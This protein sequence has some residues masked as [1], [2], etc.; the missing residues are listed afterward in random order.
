MH[1][2]DQNALAL[3]TA[4]LA[5]LV[6]LELL[7]QEVHTA[8][9][10]K[11]FEGVM[12]TSTHV[13]SIILQPKQP[14]EKNVIIFRS[15]AIIDYFPSS[16][17]DKG[18]YLSEQ[19]FISMYYQNMAADALGKGNNDLAYSY[20]AR[21]MNIDS[22]NAETI[23]TLAVLYRKDGHVDQARALYEYV[24]K[25]DIESVHTL[26]NFAVLLKKVGDEETLASIGE[27][28]LK[29]QDSNPYR[30]YDIGN[31]YL[32]RRD[33]QRAQVFFNR[34]IERGP[35]LSEGYFGL[36]KVHYLEGDLDRAEKMMV[37]ALSL[38][39]PSDDQRL[40]TAKLEALQ[41]APGH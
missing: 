8:P 29:A 9:I 6:N 10:Y 37:K 25:N 24:I 32:S 7:Y 19:A 2:K 5:K 33:F 31:E 26:S 3:L 40:Y 39:Y 21:A 14:Q 20:L 22:A 27:M 4:A 1:C 17:N 13:R 35:Y 11:R 41:N 23:N 30:W 36:A 28:Y 18:E 15:R 34:A 38:T 16:S 12:T